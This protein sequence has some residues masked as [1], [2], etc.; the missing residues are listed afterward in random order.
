M[1]RI[2]VFLLI[3]FLLITLSAQSKATDGI[4]KVENPQF[5]SKMAVLISGGAHR[6]IFQSSNLLI[7]N[8]TDVFI[9]LYNESTPVISSSIT[10]YFYSRGAQ[11][12]N[13]TVVD[14]RIERRKL[15]YAVGDKRMS[16]IT[17]FLYAGH[18]KPYSIMLLL[19]H[20]AYMAALRHEK[21][22][23]IFKYSRFLYQQED[24]AY[25][26]PQPI[27]IPSQPIVDKYKKVSEKVPLVVVSKYCPYGSLSDKIFFSNRLG[28]EHLFG[29]SYSIFVQYMRM[30]IEQKEDV[31]S[32]VTPMQ[33]GALIRGYL[34]KKKVKIE[35]DE[36][37]RT[38]LQHINGTLC[39]SDASSKCGPKNFTSQV[40]LPICEPIDDDVYI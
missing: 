11:F 33:T 32:M 4:G 23:K 18:W 12:V 2:A 40:K 31:R 16:D 35:K 36:F 26:T 27:T 25:F 38:E 22:Q 17:D 10:S 6:F 8:N 21:S 5:L 3:L 29:N 9:Y 30:W 28:A 24:N 37:Y 1:H 7:A 14:A 39:I 13:I 20:Y 15:E 19:R 34:G